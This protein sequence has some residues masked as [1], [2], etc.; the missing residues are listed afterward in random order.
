MSPNM[1]W[2]AKDGKIL[3]KQ[4]MLRSA[5]QDALLL[6]C[7]QPVV[8]GACAFQE[9]LHQAPS[10]HAE[11]HE[12]PGKAGQGCWLTK[13]I[14]SQGHKRRERL[15]HHLIALC[16]VHSCMKERCNMHELQE[17]YITC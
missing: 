8:I 14:K 3:P 4:S 17:L 10:R 12:D 2:P 13:R 7:P 11:R 6:A 1:S 5:Y 16:S 15:Q 9:A